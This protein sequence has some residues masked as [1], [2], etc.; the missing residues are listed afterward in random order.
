MDALDLREHG[1]EL[2]APILTAHG[3]RYVPGE[4][5]RGSGGLFARGAFVRGERRLEFSARYALGEVLYRA[6]GVVLGH[7][8][9]MRVAA[10][11]ARHA[12]PGFSA[13]PLDGFRHLASDLARFGAA[14]LSGSDAELA[15]VAAEAEGTRPASGFA[16][17]SRKPAS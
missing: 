8:E 16:A 15:A 11:R 3:F 2:L 17:L 9:Y 6:P 12:H 13:D 4:A 10:G 5:D 14:F 1:A 7:E